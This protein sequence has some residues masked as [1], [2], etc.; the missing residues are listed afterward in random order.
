MVDFR[1]LLTPSLADEQSKEEGPPLLAYTSGRMAKAAEDTV[2][3]WVKWRLAFS[4]VAQHAQWDES[5]RLAAAYRGI[6]RDDYTPP[7]LP[8]CQGQL[9]PFPTPFPGVAWTFAAN[10]RRV[11]SSEELL[12]HC[13]RR[14]V[15]QSQRATAAAEFF[16]ARQR[17]A[18]SL[19]GWYARLLMLF[20]RATDATS[21]EIKRSPLPQQRWIDGLHHASVKKSLL[22]DWSN[23]LLST[24]SYAVLLQPPLWDGAPPPSRVRARKDMTLRT[25]TALQARTGQ[26]A[27]LT[28]RPEQRGSASPQSRP[29]KKVASVK[30]CFRCES[31]GHFALNCPYPLV[32]QTGRNSA[33]ATRR[34]IAF[35]APVVVQ[36]KPQPKKRQNLCPKTT[37]RVCGLLAEFRASEGVTVPNTANIRAAMKKCP[38]QSG[39]EHW[40]AGLSLSE[41]S[42][43]SSSPASPMAS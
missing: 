19:T 22:C 23:D 31:P 25:T 38:E 1:P 11:K 29:T 21:E 42:N 8:G 18:E 5:E 41:G 30:L 9:V 16:V 2:A 36:Q 34:S 3:D 24:L 39:H 40:E 10:K 7:G 20:Y 15:D 14:F 35:S 37:S 13:E 12:D 28:C 4:E 6:P 27:K 32:N 43:Q 33:S 26:P 17:P